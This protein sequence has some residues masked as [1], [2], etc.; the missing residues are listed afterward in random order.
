MLV[1]FGPVEIQLGA[2]YEK[3]THTPYPHYAY[4]EGDIN[5]ILNNLN[6]ARVVH[7]K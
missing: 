2:S 5:N 1:S 7:G 6:S 3:V 4:D